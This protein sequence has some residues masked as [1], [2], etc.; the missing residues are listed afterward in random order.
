MAHIEALP[1]H[2]LKEDLEAL[3]RCVHV[4][5]KN[6]Q[7]LVT[8]VGELLHSQQFSRDVSEKYVNDLV[9]LLHN[10][11]TAV[12]SLVDSQRVVMRHRWPTARVYEGICATCDRPLPSN[13]SLSEFEAH[14]YAEKL[15]AAF[16]TD[17]AAF[18][19]KLR[20][21]CT[22]YSI[23]LPELGTTMRREQGM[24]GVEQ[25][26][27]L[28]L[29][30]D[31]LLRWNGWT[32][33]AKRYLEGQEEHFNLVPIIE[34][35]VN[36]AGEFAQWFWLEINQRSLMLIDEMNTKAMEL[37][38]WYDERVGHPDWFR[39]GEPQAPPG[40]SWKRWQLGMRKD[41]LVSGTRGFQVWAVDPAGTIVLEKDDDWTPPLLRY[42][43]RTKGTR[44]PA[45][46]FAIGRS[47]D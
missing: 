31:K 16:E 23:P 12:T 3:R 27:T 46:R 7:Q 37:K 5:S 28:Q 9:R 36:A 22:Q 4:F 18:M 24:P 35:Y 15:T 2:V 10:Y 33:S 21:Y 47:T 19:N 32:Q 17:E 14:D 45:S 1:G 42:Y 41:R 25:V 38:L 43:S 30:R 44:T 39:R 11:L 29:D 20:N 26:N 40:W 13:E 34:R 6:A 8:Q